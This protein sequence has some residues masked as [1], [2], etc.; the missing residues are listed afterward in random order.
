[1]S[2]SIVYDISQIFTER[3]IRNHPDSNH[4]AEWCRNN[5][6]VTENGKDFVLLGEVTSYDGDKKSFV[7]LVRAFFSGVPG[8]TYLATTS[9]A[10]LGK[11]RNVLRGV[12]MS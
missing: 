4:V 12:T 7:P 1:M 3:G 11:K 5:L 9:V 10:M 6:T 8:V 2:C